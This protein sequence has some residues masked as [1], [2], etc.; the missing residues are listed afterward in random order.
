MNWNSVRPLV[1]RTLAVGFTLAAP[2][3]AHPQNAKTP[4][5]NTLPKWSDGSALVA[6]AP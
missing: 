1:L 4:Y 2:R 3:M 6:G 5:P